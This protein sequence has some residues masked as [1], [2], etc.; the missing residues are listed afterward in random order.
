MSES[1]SGSSPEAESAALSVWD[2]VSLIIGIVIGTTV[3]K[4]S[5]TISANMPDPWSMLGLWVVCGGLSLIGALCYAELATTYPRLGGEYNYLTRAFGPSIGFL[6]GWSQLAIIQT[7]SIGALSY[8][9]AEY[10]VQV[11][12][13]TDDYVVWLALGAVVGLTAL[14]CLGIRSGKWTQNLL[15]SAKALGLI[16]LIVSGLRATGTASFEVE[17]ATGKSGWPLAMILILYA[18][19]GWNDAAFVAADVRDR[20]RN[21]PRALLLG[22]GVITACYVLINAA[23][24]ATL[25]FEGLRE[26][27]QPASDAMGKVFGSLGKRFISV[28]VMVS[29]LGSVNGLIFSVA[30]LHATVGT[31]HRIFAL[32]GRWSSLTKAPIWSLLVQ[33][34]IA[35]AMILCVGTDSGRQSVDRLLTVVGSNPVPWGDYFGGFETLYAASAPIFWLF[36]LTTGVAYFVLWWKD[37]EMVRPFR[38]PLFPLCPLL[39]C[40]MC[41]FG[42]YSATRYAAPLLPIIAVPF[43]MGIP[44]YFLSERWGTKSS[45]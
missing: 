37:R 20:K 31:D 6:F 4:M 9:F 13:L 2:A 12:K 1:P 34:A 32:L 24:L 10:A 22:I 35:S 29:A 40:A 21:I 3:F 18:Y 36:F 30:R 26:S 23:Y 14:N 28:L 11:F 15:T 38:A 42:L 7:G 41:G 39:F 27:R 17:N 44:L 43:L 45:R 25:G 5:G 8:V 16:L 33:G 19:G